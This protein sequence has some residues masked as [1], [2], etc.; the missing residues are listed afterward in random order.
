MFHHVINNT[1]I[2]PHEYIINPC[3]VLQRH[4]SAGSSFVSVCAGLKHQFAK[5]TTRWYQ[6]TD[7]DFELMDHPHTHI[8]LKR[9]THMIAK[10]TNRLQMGSEFLFTE[11]IFTGAIA[12]PD[13]D[14]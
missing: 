8:I 13:L 6:C 12:L 5:Y 10:L 11:N 9:L 1:L 4:Q 7:Y 2:D 14:P 3:E